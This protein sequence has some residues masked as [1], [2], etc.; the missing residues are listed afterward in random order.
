MLRIQI[1]KRIDRR[2]NV[3]AAGVGLE[4][5]A[6]N[7]A[8]LCKVMQNACRIVMR[9]VIEDVLGPGISGSSKVERGHS[10]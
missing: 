10:R 8:R 4:V 9:R 2:V 7:L 5:D 3:A 6:F 1:A